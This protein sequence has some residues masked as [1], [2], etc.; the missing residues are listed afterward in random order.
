MS[1]KQVSNKSQTETNEKKNYNYLIF[2]VL[3]LVFFGSVITWSLLVVKMPLSD[4]VEV[5]LACFFI[6]PLLLLF[7]AFI[8]CEIPEKLILGIVCLSILF[9]FCALMGFTSNNEEKLTEKK[10]DSLNSGESSLTG[11]MDGYAWNSASSDS[12]RA[13]ASDISRRL[14]ESGVSDC[15]TSFIYDALNSF[16][17]ST[18]SSILD[19]KISDIVGLSVAAAQS[20]PEN[21]R[22]Y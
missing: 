4:I 15:S 20:L 10:T 22:N 1:N 2:I 8:G 19:T 7:C 6:P 12:K 16:Y 11:S 5:S 14:N 3:A 9:W 21:E 13:L 18:E 17:S